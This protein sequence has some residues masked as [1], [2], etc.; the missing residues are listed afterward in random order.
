MPLVLARVVHMN[1][2]AVAS[3]EFG[4]RRGHVRDLAAQPHALDV[5][6]Y[7]GTDQGLAEGRPLPRR[8]LGRRL[9]VRQALLRRR[10]DAGRR[11]Q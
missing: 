7:M 6:F 8:R 10:V 4:H 11:P 3:L 2:D 5:Y 1:T 9:D